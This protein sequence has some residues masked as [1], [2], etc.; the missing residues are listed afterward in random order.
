MRYTATNSTL[1]QTAHCNKQH[2]AT[3]KGGAA[4]VFTSVCVL[5]V[6]AVVLPEIHTATRCNTVAGN[7]ARA[8][9]CKS[10]D[11]CL[12]IFALVF[13]GTCTATHCNTRGGKAAHFYMGSS[14]DLCVFVCLCCFVP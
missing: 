4:R 6:S 1:Q 14:E 2:T 5:L 10:K 7:G 8:H 3:H 9:V 12:R 13:P 11:L